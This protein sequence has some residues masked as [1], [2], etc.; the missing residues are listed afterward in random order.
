MNDGP[1]SA[2][3]PAC[4]PQPAFTPRIVALPAAVIAR[5]HLNV[6][7]DAI[8][9]A[10]EQAQA[11]VEAA[12][13]Q[14]GRAPAGA[15]F[16]HHLALAPDRFVLDVCV[17]LAAPLTSTGRVECATLEPMRVARWMHTGPREQLGQSWLH[18]AA[19]I[20]AR[21]LRTRVDCIE[22]WVVRPRTEQDPSRLKTELDQP[23]IG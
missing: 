6:P 17:P 4:A 12:L 7:R 9:S 14:Q 11:D 16:A 1:A 18:L 20:R 23:L 15:W 5:V 2:P 21:R 19:W 10:I 3:Q 13:A 22:R 8:G